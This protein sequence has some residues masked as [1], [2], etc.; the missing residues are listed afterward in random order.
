M[1]VM[2]RNPSWWHGNPTWPIDQVDWQVVAGCD[3]FIARLN[4]TLAN[5]YGGVLVAD[6]PTEDEWEYAC[7]A[8]S[9]TAFY[10]D[11]N[12]S[13]LESDPAL[14]AMANY[15]R[16]SSGSP[17]PVGSFQPNA[18][19]LYDMLGNVAEWCQNRYIRGGSWQ[20][21]A[22]DTRAA[23]RTQLSSD[24]PP[25]NKVGF[26]LVLRYKSPASGN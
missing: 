8:G 1:A 16:A 11:K 15:N 6:L 22:K 14:D 20:S 13:N 7:R 17:R 4:R 24:S 2:P 21:K 5:K 9:Q 18:W 23:W 12:I 25:D 26:R 10:N 3:G 19:G